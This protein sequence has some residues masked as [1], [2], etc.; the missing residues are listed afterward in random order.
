MFFAKIKIANNVG[1]RTDVQSPPFLLLSEFPGS[2]LNMDFLIFRIVP[3]SIAIRFI[4]S[5]S[6][7]FKSWCHGVEKSVR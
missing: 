2:F 1:N 3:I 4:S 6:I 7:V 5:F